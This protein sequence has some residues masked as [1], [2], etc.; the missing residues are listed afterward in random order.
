MSAP[1][2]DATHDPA[3]RSWVGSANAADADFPVQNLP[4]GRFRL[5]CSMSASMAIP[6]PRSPGSL[7]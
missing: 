5:S 6:A 4:L 2:L 7:R 1:E 3:L